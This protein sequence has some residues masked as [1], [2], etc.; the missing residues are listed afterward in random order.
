M[1]Q[2]RQRLLMGPS[3]PNHSNANRTGQNNLIDLN[4]DQMVPGGEMSNDTH[5]SSVIVPPPGFA[6]SPG[7]TIPPPPFIGFSAQPPPPLLRVIAPPTPSMQPTGQLNRP[8]RPP[9]TRVQP[10]R[11][12]NR[13]PTRAESVGTRSRSP[14]SPIPSIQLLEALLI[15]DGTGPK[16]DGSEH[17]IIR[18]Y[19]SDNQW[20]CAWCCVDYCR[21][22]QYEFCEFVYAHESVSPTLA[23]R[24]HSTNICSFCRIGLMS[25]Y[26]RNNCPTCRCVKCIA[27]GG[28]CHQCDCMTLGHEGK[29][30]LV[31]VDAIDTV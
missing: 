6:L 30:F 24:L 26:H 22:R 16:N 21:G 29:T 11:P 28:L 13:R 23:G 1:S 15:G 8:P 4:I 18:K 5:Q 17:V 27:M 14:F 25:Q 2:L 9:S 31:K 20:F 19:F 12:S 7:F 3:E 10:T